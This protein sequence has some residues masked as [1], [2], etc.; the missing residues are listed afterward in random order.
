M[1][2]RVYIAVSLDGYVATPDGGVGW[3]G[4]FQ[5]EEYGYTGFIEDISTIIMGRTTFE[6]VLGFGQWPYDGLRVFVLSSRS[7]DTLP[8]DTSVWHSTPAALLT[9]LREKGPKGDVWLLGGPRTIHGFRE[10]DAID[11]YELFV[12]PIL[13]GGGIPLFH[14]SE[15][16]RRL[17]LRASEACDGVVRLFYEPMARSVPPLKNTRRGK[18]QTP[19]VAGSPVY[20]NLR[21]LDAR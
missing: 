11:T 10:L 13:L 7:P 17:Q 5:N 18:G 2:F 1:R 9:H 21:R 20:G 3:L 4:P 6:Q 12:M 19:S 15:L 16:Q 14:T 8:A